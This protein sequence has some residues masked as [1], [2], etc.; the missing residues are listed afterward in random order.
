MGL[1][2]GTVLTSS[3]IHRAKLKKELAVHLRGFAPAFA[4][5]ILVATLGGSCFV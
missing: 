3:G 1:I 4:V 5:L 2:A